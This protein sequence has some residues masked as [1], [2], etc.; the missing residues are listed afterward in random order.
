MP[1]DRV[2]VGCFE[3]RD[4]LIPTP[5]NLMCMSTGDYTEASTHLPP[6]WPRL[7]CKP[8]RGQHVGYMQAGH[9]G[10]GRGGWSGP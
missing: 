3:A 5:L 10:A 7:F 1:A 2:N 8:F 6:L 9:L 4:S